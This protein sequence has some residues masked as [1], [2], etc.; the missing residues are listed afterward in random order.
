MSLEVQFSFSVKLQCS[1]TTTLDELKELILKQSVPKKLDL[2]YVFFGNLRNYS[3]LK[4]QSLI[5][6]CSHAD[7]SLLYSLENGRLVKTLLKRKS[8]YPNP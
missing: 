2:L 6:R 8:L 4:L 5:E 7:T 1:E 3:L